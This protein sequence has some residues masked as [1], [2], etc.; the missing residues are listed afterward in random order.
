M[1]FSLQCHLPCFLCSI[2]SRK[3]GSR[4]TCKQRK[5]L[6]EIDL[7]ICHYKTAWWA[8][9]ALIVIPCHVMLEGDLEFKWLGS[10]MA[11]FFPLSYSLAVF[12][13]GCTDC[14]SC[15]VNTFQLNK[16]TW[17]IWATVKN[18]ASSS[19]QGEVSDSEDGGRMWS[20]LTNIFMSQW[21]RKPFCNW[22]TNSCIFRSRLNH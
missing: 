14:P 22:W 10:L 19:V 4:A 6:I 9:P 8:F 18:A 15:L 13:F 1:L 7:L 16:A 3:M 20:P 5:L 17:A 2:F 12:L 11:I 21:G